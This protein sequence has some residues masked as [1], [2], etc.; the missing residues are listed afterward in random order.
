MKTVRPLLYIF[1]LAS[2]I[3]LGQ[4]DDADNQKKL[5][6]GYDIS[7]PE[8]IKANILKFASDS[9]LTITQNVETEVKKKPRAGAKNKTLFLPNTD[10]AVLDFVKGYYK[11]AANNMTFYIDPINLKEPDFDFSNNREYVL[12]LK[13]AKELMASQAS[14]RGFSEDQLESEEYY[15]S[16]WGQL[17]YDRINMGEIWVGMTEEMAKVGG[18]Y[19]GPY[20]V[21]TAV[22]VYG[23]Q[24]HWEC[25]NGM[26]LTF[27]GGILKAFASSN[28]SQFNNNMGLRKGFV[29]TRYE[30]D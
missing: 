4:N 23:K 16:K 5:I 11:L 9:L 14:N 17:I 22:T 13:G 10:I 8:E 25:R 3:T 27:E 19:P 7:D 6:Y 2:Y 21:N 28:Y 20:Y 1:L 30:N 12:E 29:N 26:R 24:Q 15:V 18:L